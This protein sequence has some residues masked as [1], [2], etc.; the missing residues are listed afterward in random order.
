MCQCPANRGKKRCRI[1][2]GA[3]G[4]GGQK[5]ER[6][7]AFKHGGWSNDAV[8]LRRAAGRLLRVVRDSGRAVE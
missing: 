3:N 7:G 2:G 6:N 4:S 8:A 1:H 5:G